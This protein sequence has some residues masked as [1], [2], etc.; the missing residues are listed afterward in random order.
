MSYRPLPFLLL[1]LLSAC[2]TH[3]GAIPAPATPVPVT[4]A[5]VAVTTTAEPVYKP[6]PAQTLQSLLTAEM[7]V[8]RQ[9]PDIT[10]NNYVEQAVATRDPGVVARATTI[11]QVLNQPQSLPLSQLWA[12]V[13]PQSADAWYLVALNSMR[14]LRYDIAVPALDRLIVLQP[15]ADL[16]QLFLAVIPNTQQGRDV[17]FDKLGTLAQTHPANAQLRFAQALLKE[18]SQQPA[19]ALDIARIA[20]QLRPQSSQITL[21]EAKILTELNRNKEATQLLAATLKQQPDNYNLRLNYARALI[22]FGDPKG[23]QRE[24]QTLIS[25]LPNDNK[26]H[27]GLALIAFDN[28]DDATAERELNRLSGTDDYADEAHYYLGLLA[29]R[30]NHKEEAM[31]AF[32]KVQAGNQYLPAVAEQSRMLAADGKLP[33]ARQR[34]VE[35]RQQYPEQKVAL[36]QLEAELLSSNNQP[37]AAWDLLNS[38]LQEQPENTALL[39]ARGMAAEQLDRLDDF[40]ADLRE[41]LRYEPEN[42]S[43][44][45]ALGYTLADRTNRL[46][47]AA[48]YI[49][50]AFALKPDDPAIIDSMGWLK[51]KQGDS[52]GA[53]VDLRHAYTLYPDDEIAAHLGEVLWVLGEHAEAKRLWAEALKLHPKSPHILPVQQRL[54]PA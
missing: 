28:H 16:E 52:K 1:P 30:Q 53:L 8:T 50:H 14:Q 29:E 54:N 49:L 24:F 7:A 27:L 9:R 18:Q 47:E 4:S 22:R 37:Q 5:P 21:L 2:V 33:E 26:L 48:P 44:L 32:A 31:A 15:E 34:L 12:E 25:Q 46:S 35:A 39:L 43:A 11:A 38:A 17:F 40:E 45:N 23:A 20:R 13:A 41:V 10:L 3:P 19:A 42:P 6:F 36:Y 51:F